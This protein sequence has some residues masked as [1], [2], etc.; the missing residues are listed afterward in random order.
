MAHLPQ[1][2]GADLRR[3]GPTAVLGAL[4]AGGLLVALTTAAPSAATFAAMPMVAFGTYGAVKCF[5]TVS[6]VE[7]GVDPSCGCPEYEYVDVGRSDAERCVGGACLG[8]ATVA[9]LVLAATALG[10]A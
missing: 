8:V 10:L 2:A 3:T 6:K 7:T 9:G 4:L 5:S 1:L